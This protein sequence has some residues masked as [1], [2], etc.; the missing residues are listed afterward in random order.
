M[1]K[2][3]EI[4]KSFTA[5]NQVL[6]ALGSTFNIDELQDFM[7]EQEQ[8]DC[9]VYHHFSPGLYIREVNIA[10]GTIAIG[11]RQKFEHLNIF[12]KGRVTFANGDGTLKEMKAPMIFTGKPGRKCG[13]IHEDMVWLNV[14]ATDE[15]DIGTLEDTYL[16]KDPDWQGDV[17]MDSFTI[18]QDREDYKAV[19]RE[20]NYTEEMVQ[21]E[22]DAEPIIDFPSGSYWVRTGPSAIDGTGLFV[23]G[24]VRKDGVIAPATVSGKK[25]PAGR[26]T[27]HAKTPNATM[28]VIAGDIYLIALRDIEGCKGGQIGEEITIDYRVPLGLR[29][30]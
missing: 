29:R 16:D 1:I 28:Q 2:D 13:Y 23:T 12:L 5:E 4:F 27:N 6:A 22:M 15:T 25:T 18:L 11:H 9:P 24:N 8:A 20:H 7:L 10:A 21:A 26:Y 17:N 3:I 30:D 14:Y 19:L